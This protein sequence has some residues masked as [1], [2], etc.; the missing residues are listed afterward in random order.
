MDAGIAMILVLV[1]AYLCL[2]WANTLVNSTIE[3]HDTAEKQLE[4]ITAS[5]RLIND[6]DCL[7]KVDDTVGRVVP[8][9][10]DTK[11][12][13]STTC[14]KNYG[15]NTEHEGLVVR[16]LVFLDKQGGKVGV[17]EVW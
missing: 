1:L 7:A 11:R 6:P 4:L 2:T 8:Q 9:T 15:I 3:I 13:I 10:I 16:R 5:D 12:N 14:H 17:L